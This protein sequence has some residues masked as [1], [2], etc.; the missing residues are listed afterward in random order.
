MTIESKVL[1]V[2]NDRKLI[3]WWDKEEVYYNVVGWVA[4]AKSTAG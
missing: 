4:N 1:R 3:S 2:T